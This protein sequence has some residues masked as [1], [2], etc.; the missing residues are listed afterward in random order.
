MIPVHR[1]IWSPEIVTSPV[2]NTITILLS[3][4]LQNLSSDF[5]F[6]TWLGFSQ[7]GLAAPA[8]I[9][10]RSVYK[11][12]RHRPFWFLSRYRISSEPSGRTLSKL[13]TWIFLNPLM[14]LPETIPVCQ[15]IWPPDSHL[16]NHDFPFLNT[17]NIA[18]YPYQSLPYPY[19]YSYPSSYH[20]LLFWPILAW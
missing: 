10:F 15:L 13:C 17:I 18:P 11:Y 8:R 5:F 14:G 1:L 12:G 2:L 4:L 20:T 9:G 3:H 6:K 7:S 19:S 16:R